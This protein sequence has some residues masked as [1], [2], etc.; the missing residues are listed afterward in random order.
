MANM[1]RGPHWTK[2]GVAGSKGCGSA[3]RAAPIGYLH[4]HDP[5]KLREVDHASSICT[6]SHP[7]AEAACIGAAYLVKLALDG[8][9][10]EN[11]IP[12]LLQF[13]EGI[14]SEFDEVITLMN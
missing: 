4:K 10:P 12:K 8:L 6:Y 7:T 11:M 13:S 9:K 14:S 5:E 3:M 1:E 2:S